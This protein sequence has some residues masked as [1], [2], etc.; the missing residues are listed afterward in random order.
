MVGLPITFCNKNDYNKEFREHP[1]FPFP[2]L[3]R[4]KQNIANQYCDSHVTILVILN[5]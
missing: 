5:F 3:S 2:E 1:N 4:E